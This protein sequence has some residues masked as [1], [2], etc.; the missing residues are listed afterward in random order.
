MIEVTVFAPEK[1]GSKAAGEN[2][3]KVTLALHEV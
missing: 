3:H 1:R 2:R